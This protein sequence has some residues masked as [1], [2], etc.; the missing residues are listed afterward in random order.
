V[1]SL[2]DGRYDD[3]R[4]S[5]EMKDD[6]RAPSSEEAVHDGDTSGACIISLSPTLSLPPSTVAVAVSGRG[7]PFLLALSTYVCDALRLRWG[8]VGGGLG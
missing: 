5:G 6:G 2:A 8:W 1:D 4:E 3:C 7:T